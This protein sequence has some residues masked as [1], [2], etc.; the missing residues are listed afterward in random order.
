MVL[1]KPML[2]LLRKPLKSYIVLTTTANR[3][4]SQ[5]GSTSWENALQLVWRLRNLS[6]H[7]SF[8]SSD[9]EIFKSNTI[10]I[11]VNDAKL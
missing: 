2:F 7:T 11:N 3:S 10:H 9:T 1:H 5:K 4:L 6:N 8:S